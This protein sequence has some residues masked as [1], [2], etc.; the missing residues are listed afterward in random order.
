MYPR[1]R[2]T[3]LSVHLAVAPWVEKMGEPV[4]LAGG[5]IPILDQHRTYTFT[6]HKITTGH[7]HIS[8]QNV[9]CL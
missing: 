8:E 5:P 4:D 3:V 9:L 2:L 7:W 1:P 6:V